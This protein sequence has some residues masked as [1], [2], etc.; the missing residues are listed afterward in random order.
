MLMSLSV[1]LIKYSPF[2]LI[3]PKYCSTDEYSGLKTGVPASFSELSDK[4]LKKCGGVPLAIITIASLLANK[5][6]DITEWQEVCSSIGSGLIS[7]ND[8]YNGMKKILLLSYYDLPSHM[9]TCFLY[10]SMYPED[11]ITNCF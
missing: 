6:Y 4:I 2:V 1:A 8:M 9:K 10:I 7:S 11:V 3:A 5:S